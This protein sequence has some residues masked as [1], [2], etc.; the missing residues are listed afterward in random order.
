M[1]EMN[2][3]GRQPSEINWDEVL[4][5]PMEEI[6]LPPLEKR[7]GWILDIGA[8]G[9]GIIGLLGGTRVVGVDKSRTELEETSDDSLRIVMDARDLGFLD[10]TFETA[11][12]FYSLMYMSLETVDNVLEE[13]K[14][15][16]KPGGELYIW[17]AIVE[18]PPEVDKK[19][20]LVQVSVVFPDGRLGEG[21]YGMDIRRQGIETFK[22]IAQHHGFVVLNEE[23][24]EH[25]FF[26]RLRKE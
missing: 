19:Y 10:G 15:V 25:S 6:K 18:V 22:E 17:D 5:F 7:S 1:N 12:L 20:F 8:G 2:R 9:E 24:K 4:V 16:L 11:T 21:R 23:A 3:G 14:R 26:L 13:V